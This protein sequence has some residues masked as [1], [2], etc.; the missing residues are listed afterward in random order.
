ME[1]AY[2]IIDPAIPLA[3]I[4]KGI[5]FCRWSWK[6]ESEETEKTPYTRL[7][8]DDDSKTYIY[9]REEHKDVF[10][11]RYFYVEGEDI[12]SVV[13]KLY[14]LADILDTPELIHRYETVE[15]P[16][17]R[18]SAVYQLG[19]AMTGKGFD[20]KVRDVFQKALQD[21]EPGVRIAALWGMAWSQWT[22]LLPLIEE[23]A[24]DTVVEVS[25][26]ARTLRE[27]FTRN[28]DE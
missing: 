7:Y 19:I 13:K 23:A 4:V 16:R 6:D 28:K 2:L 17:Q 20:P 21:D 11:S 26:A 9:Y 3:K 22:E 14:T 12:E 25:R 18:G 15:E 5:Y 1:K 10:E 24:D 27:A 8:V